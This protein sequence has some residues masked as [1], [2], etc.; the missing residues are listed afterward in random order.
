MNQGNKVIIFDTTLRDGEQAPG[1]SMTLGEKLKIAHALKE[2]NVDVIE[3]G[4]AAASPGDF[5]SVKA[6]ASEIDGPTIC[7]LA[8]C[9]ERD[10][11]QASLA[12]EPTS[13]KRIHV[14]VATSEIHLKHKLNM[15]KEEVLKAAF[16]GVKMAKS[17]C[18][19]VEF[20]PEDASRTDH[21]FLTEVVNAAIDAVSGA[22]T[23]LSVPGLTV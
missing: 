11:E 5:E 17:F 21:D 18:D 23:R 20:S 3:A 8:R 19:D 22:V 16:E 14:F 10:I 2:L 4:F 1:C 9:N 13:N 12:L 15:A 6:I 7:T